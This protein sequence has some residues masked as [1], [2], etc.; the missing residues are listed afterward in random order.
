MH[1]LN[2]I[3]ISAVIGLVTGIGQAIAGPK[4]DEIGRL[5]ADL[6]PM[7]SERAGNGAGTIPEWTGGITA[8]PAG[9][10]P[11]DHHPFSALAEGTERHWRV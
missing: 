4:P 9:Y 1:T 3:A 11:G 8:P 2:R 10:S 5:S 6:T 7:G